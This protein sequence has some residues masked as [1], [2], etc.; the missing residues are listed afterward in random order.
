MS[1][2][3]FGPWDV[4]INIG[5]L[6]LFWNDCSYLYEKQPM[7]ILRVR[8]CTLSVLPLSYVG[9]SN[10]DFVLVLS[11][12][13]LGRDVVDHSDYRSLVEA[14]HM[15]LNFGAISRSW[16]NFELTTFELYTCNV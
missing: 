1:S 6:R 8:L 12:S 11:F 7:C 3:V 2:W 15:Q 5:I 14:G 4:S 13:F 16:L 9:L 10:I